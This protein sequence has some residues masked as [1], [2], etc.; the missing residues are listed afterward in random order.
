MNHHS[1]APR[2]HHLKAQGNALGMSPNIFPS[3][4]RA[5]SSP[6]ACVW[7][8]SPLGSTPSGRGIIMMPIGPGALPWAIADRPIGAL[9]NAFP[10]ETLLDVFPNE[11]LLNTVTQWCIAECVPQ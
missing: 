9:L 10:N 2:G 7:N 11:A 6:N 3:P 8:S 5:A 4:E 1:A